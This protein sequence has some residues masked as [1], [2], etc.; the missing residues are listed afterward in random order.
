MTSSPTTTDH[1]AQADRDREQVEAPVREF[2]DHH[3]KYYERSWDTREHGLHLGIF[4][5]SSGMD[6]D[7]ESA[8]QQ[9]RDHV[10]ELL[11][12]IR[13][14]ADR[15]RVLDVCCGTGATLAQ[16]VR[17]HG[18]FGI[19]V[20][21]SA[22]QLELAA[23]LRQA[24]GRHGHLVFRQGSASE[25]ESVVRDQA[26]FTHAFSQEGLLF[27][28]DKR[29]AV[30]GLFRLLTFGAALV[31]TDFVP[32]LSKQEL[33][34]ALRARVYEDVKWADGL[35]LQGYLD[36][37]QEAGFTLIQAELRPLDM[38]MTYEKLIPRTQAMADDD[39]TYAFLAKRYAGIVKAVDDGAL[40]WA[41]IAARKP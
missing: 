4:D 41:W 40:S 26:P 34:A 31:I 10:V 23:R 19:G 32:L 9:S 11:G 3:A 21:L 2:F 15:S 20:D 36:L 33:D 24:D 35:K 29:A 39:A 18:C 5:G 16:I 22:G 14:L 7:L 27:A 38:R 25:I 28:H 13:A 30:Q 6:G 1:R 12:R 37:L 8:Y 17:R